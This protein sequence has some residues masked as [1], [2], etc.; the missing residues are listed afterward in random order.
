MSLLMAS[1]ICVHFS[2]LVVF[3]EH[4][5]PP[6]NTVEHTEA[7]ILVCTTSNAKCHETTLMVKLL[8]I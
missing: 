7:K 1:V 8:I 4:R 6:H 5:H 2:D 3:V